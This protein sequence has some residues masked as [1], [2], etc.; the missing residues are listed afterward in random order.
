MQ[1]KEDLPFGRYAQEMS[2]DP[3]HIL[4]QLEAKEDLKAIPF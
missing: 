1:W 3:I 2:D 4:L